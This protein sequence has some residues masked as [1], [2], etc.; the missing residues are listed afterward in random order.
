[1]LDEADW[2]KHTTIP[3]VYGMPHYTEEN[4]RLFL[5]AT[6]N[7]LWRSFIPPVHL[8][9]GNLK[10]AVINAYRNEKG[11]LTMQPFFDLLAL[12]ELGHAFQF[13]A[14]LNIQ[15]KW[16]G[17][18]FANVFLHTYIAEKEPRMLNALTVFPKMVI[19]N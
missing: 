15:R 17:E 16:M 9:P 2:K 4:Q 1:V 8:L 5:A 3:M 7:D 19:E 10:E 11:E 6:D 12:H 14:G 13:Q 18:L